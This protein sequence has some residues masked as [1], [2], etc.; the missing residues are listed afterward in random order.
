MGGLKHSGLRDWLKPRFPLEMAAASLATLVLVVLVG[1]MGRGSRDSSTPKLVLQAAPRVV[2]AQ[3][4]ADERT[5]EF[6]EKFAL[7]HVSAP[8]PE[9]MISD[10]DRAAPPRPPERAALAQPQ[11]EKPRPQIVRTIATKPP[12]KPVE[13]AEAEAPVVP[14]PAVAR[15]QQTGFRIPVVSDVADRLP[16]GRDIM[17]GVGAMGRRI[18]S[19]F[20]KS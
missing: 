13:T 9:S 12:Q 15:V 20:G 8:L 7:A 4:A 18:G 14:Q 17:D 1:D 11:R 3:P 10:V 16:T 5:T 6:I 19:I 2:V